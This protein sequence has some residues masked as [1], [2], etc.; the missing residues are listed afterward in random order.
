MAV[1]QRVVDVVSR[2]LKHPNSIIELLRNTIFLV[3]S[4]VVGAC[5]R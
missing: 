4:D 5:V 2:A 3:A 1:V